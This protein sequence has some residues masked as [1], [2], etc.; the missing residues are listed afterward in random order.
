EGFL[1]LIGTTSKDYSLVAGLRGST[2]NY[3]HWDFSIN[4][5]INELEFNVLNSFNRSL[6]P[7]S[8][9]QFYSG[10]LKN[11]QTILN[12]DFSKAFDV[13]RPT[14]LAFGAESRDEEYSIFAGEPAS[15]QIGPFGGAPGAQV[16][17]GFQPGDAGANSRD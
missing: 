5:G 2:T 15:Y 6:G 14:T 1:P 4:R 8:P 11:A 10:T 7:T 12:L 16:F 9:T 3:L 13:A 17:P